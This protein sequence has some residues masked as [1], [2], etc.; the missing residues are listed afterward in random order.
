MRETTVVDALE[1]ARERQRR[2]RCPACDAVASIRGL[3]GE[4]HWACLDCDA[5]GIGYR[6]RSAA[7]ADLDRRR[8]E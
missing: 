3:G 2:K 4:Y 8:D 1:H 6:T 7:L 5:V